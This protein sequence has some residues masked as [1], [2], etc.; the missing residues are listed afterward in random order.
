MR[1]GTLPAP[2]VERWRALLPTE[3]DLASPFLHPA[4]SLAAAEVLEGVEVCVVTSNGTPVGFYPFERIEPSA[5]RPVGGAMSNFQG[6]IAAHGVAWSATELVRGA[7]LHALGFHHQ[8]RGQPAFDAYVQRTAE[9]PLIDLAGGWDAYL[10][11]RRAA[12]V[13]SFNAL[14]RKMR[15]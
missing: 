15:K 12:G 2:L 10:D 8:V 7:R 5:G 3:G 6:M 14:P 13:S 11:A 4:Y 9:S 1:A